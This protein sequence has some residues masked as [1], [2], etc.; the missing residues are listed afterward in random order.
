M[1]HLRITSSIELK[2]SALAAVLGGGYRAIPAPRTAQ[3]AIASSIDL[4]FVVKYRTDV[5]ITKRDLTV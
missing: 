5:L 3:G 4:M 1:G 2:F